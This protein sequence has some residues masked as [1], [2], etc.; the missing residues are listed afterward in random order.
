M[1]DTPPRKK[2][3]T[4]TL[5]AR[6]AS[7]PGYA[8]IYQRCDCANK[9]FCQRYLAATSLRKMSN[10]FSASAMARYLSARAVEQ[11]HEKLM[12]LINEITRLLDEK[13]ERLRPDPP[14][15]ASQPCAK[16]PVAR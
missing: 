12:E 13:E 4:L 6:L 1:S 3:G 2:K 7:V 16:T 8:S 10:L 15:R 14:R 11:D 5:P 9:S